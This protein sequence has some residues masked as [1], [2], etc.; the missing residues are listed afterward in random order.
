MAPRIGEFLAAL[1]EQTVE[2]RHPIYHFRGD[3]TPLSPGQVAGMA[4]DLIELSDRLRLNY[5]SLATEAVRLAGL[6]QDTLMRRKAEL[7]PEEAHRLW[8]VNTGGKGTA[9]R[10]RYFQ[11][12]YLAS[13]DALAAFRVL[14][15]RPIKGKV[16]G[17]TPDGR[18]PEQYADAIDALLRAAES[19]AGQGSAFY[20]EHAAR[21]ADEAS[22]MFLDGDSP[23]PKSFDRE[24]TLIDG[25][26]FPSFY[27]SYLG[28]DDLMWSF[29][30][31]ANALEASD[32]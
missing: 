29:W 16:A 17:Q 21:F 11:A 8:K 19:G 7:K 2:H 32:R 25:T 18:I 12:H 14:P 4:A 10:A 24:P 23:L 13:A 27:H 15:E 20:L 28:G 5:D 31:L 9:E 1:A 3:E 22:G 30:R 26:P 6:S